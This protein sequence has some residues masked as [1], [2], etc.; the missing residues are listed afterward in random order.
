LSVF[1]FILVPLAIIVGVGVSEILGSW[2]QQIRNRHRRPLHPLQ[3][4]SSAFILFF[5]MAYLWAMWLM[6]D[7]VWTFPLYLLAAAPGLALALAAH[8][9]EID[10]SADAP[11]V[12][13]Q[14]FRNAPPTYALLALM[15]ISIIT[16]SLTTE[17]REQLPDP[18]NL[19][20]VTSVR[21]VILALLVSLVWSKNVKYHSA[22]LAALWLGALGLVTRLAFR[23]AESAA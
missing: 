12:L 10:T 3:I 4:T 14:Y 15:P 16:I 5:C 7:I 21:I 18:P 1:E 11:P 2:G 20:A 9:T 6:R 22:A 19:L 13:E 17:V 8:I 23:I